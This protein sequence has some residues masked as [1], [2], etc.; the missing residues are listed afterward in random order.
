MGADANTSAVSTMRKRATYDDLL[1]LPENVV[2][3]IIDGELIV[4]PRPAY[5]HAIGAT[6]L[7]GL[8]LGPYQLGRTGPGGWWIV[9]EPELHFPA[10]LKGD[11]DVLVPD[12]AGWRR[13]RIPDF[14][15][16]KFSEIAPDWACEVL[17]PNRPKL[18]REQKLPLYAKNGVGLVWIVDPVGQTLE[19]FRCENGTPTLMLFAS[20]R[21]EV[22]AEPFVEVGIP[23]PFLWG[24]TEDSAS[25]T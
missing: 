19:V 10:R 17:A 6:V 1:A 21:E 20:G 7:G 3:E 18:D 15:E 12:L 16:L 5:R 8:L 11:K 13:A 2:G 22:H 4:S 24:E 25:T 14:I 23:L 9:Q